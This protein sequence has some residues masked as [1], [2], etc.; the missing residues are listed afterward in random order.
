MNENTLAVFDMETTGQNPQTCSPVQIAM[1]MVHPRTLKVMSGGTF[2]SFVKPE[3]DKDGNLIYEQGALEYLAKH[4][5]KKP[6]QLLE[7]WKTY[8]PQK[9]VWEALVKFTRRFHKVGTKKKSMFSAPVRCG[10]NIIKFD[11]PIIDRLA[12]KYKNVLKD[13]TCNLFHPRDNLDLMNWMFPWFENDAE[14]ESYNLDYLREY[15]GITTDGA[16][17]ALKDTEDCVKILQRFLGLYRR[18]TKQIVF[19]GALK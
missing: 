17:D 2:N 4:Q 16:H 10:W 7:E 14:V 5:N 12:V 9:S 15:F 13:G 18:L 3:S 19:K 6:E 8:P 1:V 11:N